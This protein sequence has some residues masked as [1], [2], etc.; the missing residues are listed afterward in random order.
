MKKV[1]IACEESQIVCSAMRA[2]GI[3][4]YSCDVIP[5]SGAHPEWH[6]QDDVANIL[7][8]DW[9]AVIAFPPCTHLCSSGARWFEEKRIDGRQAA[10]IEFFMQFTTLS[11]PVVIENPVGIMST[12]YRPPDQIIQPWQYGHEET[13]ATCLWLSGFPLLQPTKIVFGSE[14]RVWRMAPSLNRSKLRS[15]TYIG[16]AQAMATQWRFHLGVVNNIIYEPHK[17]A[18]LLR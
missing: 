14:Q 13:K 5:T 4:A 11:C 7:Y 18:Q 12:L 15:R 10:G 2:Q 6:I 8:D 17:V 1:L 9:H 3:E 16:V